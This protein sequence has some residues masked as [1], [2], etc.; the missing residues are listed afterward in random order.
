MR[1]TRLTFLLFVP[2][3]CGALAVLKALDQQV[4]RLVNAI[5][6]M[7]LAEK[8]LIVL[9]SDNGPTAWN[10]YYR[11]R[12]YLPSPI[13]HPQPLGRWPPALSL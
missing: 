4:G 9:T 2:L 3:V 12:Y 7:G 10:R 11:D 13:S 5:D 6:D 1:T 8:T